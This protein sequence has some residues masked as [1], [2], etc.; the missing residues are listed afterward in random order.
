MEAPVAYDPAALSYVDSA[1][2]SSPGFLATW[3]IPV[4]DALA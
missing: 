2:A 3:I 1:V 4:N